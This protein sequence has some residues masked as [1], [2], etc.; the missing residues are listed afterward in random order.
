MQSQCLSRVVHV[1]LLLDWL[2]YQQ[3]QLL[4]QLILCD[5]TW[6]FFMVLAQRKMQTTSY[7][8]EPPIVG[9]I[10]FNANNYTKSS[11]KFLLYLNV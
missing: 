7:W 5:N 2:P 10:S 4:W 11:I 1:F 9:F 8:I 3:E 6:I